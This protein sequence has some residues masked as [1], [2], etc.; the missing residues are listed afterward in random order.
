MKPRL[1]ADENTSHRMVAA[2]RQIETGF[3]IIHIS[4]WQEGPVCRPKT[5]RC[6]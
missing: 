3:P 2:C 5:L 4:E 6:W 1:L